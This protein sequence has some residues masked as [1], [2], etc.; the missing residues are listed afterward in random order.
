VAHIPALSPS[1]RIR[2][3]LASGTLVS[4][5]SV[6]R[7]TAR[8]LVE[9]GNPAFFVGGIAWVAIG[10]PAPWFVLAA[11]A[12][13]IAVRAVDVEARA[14]FVPG[15]LYGSV[16]DALGRTLATIAVSA[17]LVE[18]LMLGPLAAVVA[19]HYLM[20]IARA[21]VGANPSGPGLAGDDGPAVLAV[22]LLGLVWWWQRQGRVVPDR[23]LSR[24]VGASVAILAIV[25]VWGGATTWF[26]GAA[27]PP[28]RLPTIG[29]FTWGNAAGSS[30]SLA[31]LA[32]AATLAAGLGAAL[33]AVGGVDVLSQ[34]AVDL[35]QPRIRNLQR[36]ARLVAL[37]GVLVTGAFAF[38][39]VALVP[40]AQR[41]AWIDAPLA[42]VALR[43]AGPIWLRVLAFLG[44]V[45][46]ACVFMSAAVRSAAAAVHG[47]LS[48]LV[49]EGICHSALRTLHPRFGTP[50]RLIDVT[51]IASIGIVLV[52]S[53]EMTW[54]A[55]VYA[56]GL[57]WSAVLKTIALVRFRFLRPG[58]RAYRVPVNVTIGRR[59]WPVGLI[60]LTGLLA[61]P[62]L[63]LLLALDAPSI[64]GAA[65][66]A[67]VSVLLIM[68]ERAAAARP[69]PSRAAL[70]EFQLLPSG[71]DDLTHVEA[72]PGNVLVTVRKP[73][74]L[75]HLTAA[76]REAGDRD[77]VAMT[78]RLVGVDVPDDP[79]AT[80]R[81]TD[82]ER[83]LLSAV[84]ALAERE[85]RP[86]RLLIVPGVNV[87]D[88]VV[89]TALRLGSAEIHTGESE[90]LSAD[91][92]ARLLGEAWERAPHARGVD[93][94]LV[95]HHPRGSTAAYHLGAHAP[96][97]KPEDFDVIHRLWLDAAKTIGPHVH[98]RDVVRAALTL[99]EQ[100]LSGPDRE[101]A[102][103]LVRETARPADELAAVIRQRDFGRLR[104]MVRNRP[105]SDLAAVLTDLSLEDQVLVFRILPRK[106]AAATFEYL[107]AED[108]H[109][110]LKAMASEDV[111][112]LL[113][114]MAPDDRTMFLEELPAEVTRH[115]LAQLTPEERAVAVG[116]LGYPEGSI[117]R[118]MTPQYVAVREDWT[119]AQVLDY[120]RA[121]GQ[122]SET[123]N[124]IYVVDDRGTLIDDI[125]IRELLLASPSDL[126]RSL[127]DRR[128]VGL[129][130]TDDQETAVAV[131]RREDRTALPVTDSAGV[132]I[133]IVTV[134]DVLDV[135]EA[136]ATED[137]Q[138]FGGSEALDEPY[139]EI[140][141]L[142]MIQ[143]RAGWLTALF[144]GEM[145]TATAMGFFEHEIEK[146]VILA[147]FVP[148]IISSGGNSGSQASTL[149][150]RALALGEVKLVDWW[151]VMRREIGAGLA[152]GGILGT[153]GF[154]RITIWSSFSSIYGVHWLLVAVTVALALVGV[155]LWGT[156]VGSLLPFL[157]RRLGFDPAVSSAPFVATLVDVTGLVIYFSVGIVILR[158][159]LL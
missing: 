27:L 71:A 59:E 114:D 135:A 87:F 119:I 91:A 152:L 105:A 100:Q 23:T 57:V 36:V 89:E 45:G 147:L 58:A 66:V 69:D 88:S 137:I 90:T 124:V 75:T 102:L 103:E 98:H 8:A 1:A 111:A 54:L 110:L 148:L 22:I 159:T 35:E 129:K 65:L 121:H 15:G 72:R 61:A 55:R 153:I 127:M 133:G 108:Q 13:S 41:V 94:R 12:L 149:V 17:L 62:G 80:P 10:S 101:K 113:N 93:V 32:G 77:V 115:L 151:R 109:G 128:F 47:V 60:L 112:A 86:V 6:W 50:S 48:R 141:F 155:V 16:R 46:A 139:M 145:L 53:G 82:D 158:G 26:N 95:V 4:Y 81:A 2:V 118:R 33:P 49:D 20:A 24:A 99:M 85:A 106:A 132:L 44:V 125:R 136:E 64:A 56:V 63:G 130:A 123:L 97:L 156:L 92:Q 122:D 76:L 70:D 157:L 78:V 146:A 39:L 51:A 28:L 7:A 52:S 116:L 120:I 5:V 68:S 131:F 79:S 38:L 83:R 11:I 140:A 29:P 150:I 3:V 18:R 14:L 67:S 126:V 43:L 34:V 142:R 134:D 144:L 96:A 25:A 84:V 154:L 19:G 74:A 40:E 37:F 138:R 21:L 42:G 31:W 73:G 117:G 107:S 143:K 104:D 30:P 9:L